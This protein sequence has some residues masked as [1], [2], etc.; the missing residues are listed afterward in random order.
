MPA[1]VTLVRVQPDGASNEVRLK[2]GESVLGRGEGCQLRIP[3]GDVSRRHCSIVLDDDGLRIA[4]N[5]SRN[6]THVNGEEIE[7]HELRPGDVITVGHF[8]FVV[9]LDGDPAEIDASEKYKIG[10]AAIAPTSGVASERGGSEAEAEASPSAGSGSGGLLQSEGLAS[11]DP[12]D[13]SV[14]D[15]DFDLGD[16]DEDEQPPL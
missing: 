3:A 8:V 7:S 5:Q 2:P 12:E 15:F 10:A 11:G 1:E 4:D 14:F 16:E 13:S 6:G 9:R